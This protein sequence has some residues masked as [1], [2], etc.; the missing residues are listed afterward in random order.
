MPQLNLVPHILLE[1]FAQAPVPVPTLCQ[2]PKTKA[3]HKI[4]SA[5]RIP[6]HGAPQGQRACLLRRP[7]PQCAGTR[8]RT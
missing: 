4:W 2:S 7:L 5:I 3:A 8:A 1:R 6:R